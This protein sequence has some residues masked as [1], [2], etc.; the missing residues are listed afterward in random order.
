MPNP[1]HDDEREAAL[2]RLRELVE[3]PDHLGFNSSGEPDSILL[4]QC[5]VSD[6][7]MACFRFFPAFEWIHL[8]ECP[9]TDA[10]LTHLSGMHQL[11]FLDLME[12]DGITDAGLIH[13]RNLHSLETLGLFGCSITD[14]GL[15]ELEALK[16]LRKLTL[17][18][19][20][21][22]LSDAGIARLLGA[23]GSIP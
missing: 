19:E 2:A 18:E 4:F 12:N 20:N 21:R 13:L 11:R 23:I 1:G 3:I 9:I 7:D 8:G 17:D 10:G 14:A 16:N 6:Q 15:V 5:R 22:N